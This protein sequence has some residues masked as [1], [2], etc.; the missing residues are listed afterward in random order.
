VASLPA[1]AGAVRD[2]QGGQVLPQ[3]LL[4]R[5]SGVVSADQALAMRR[6]GPA[7]RRTLPARCG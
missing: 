5:G 7:P 2:A 1:E 3:R 6:Q 4:L